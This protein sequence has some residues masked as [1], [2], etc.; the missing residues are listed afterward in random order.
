[1]TN[2]RFSMEYKFNSRSIAQVFLDLIREFNGKKVE[3]KGFLSDEKDL[4]VK[5]L[6]NLCDDSKS[7]FSFEDRVIKLNDP[8]YIIGDIC[9]RLQDLFTIESRLWHSFPIV[10]A[11]YLFLGNF[12]EFGGNGIEC[13]IY[14][15]ALKLIAPKKIFLIKGCHEVGDVG[16]VRDV[17]DFQIKN[18]FQKECTQKYGQKIGLK[19]WQLI[20]GVFD[21]LPIAAI[22]NES[23]FC[24][25]GGIPQSIEKVRDINDMSTDRKNSKQ[26]S[27]VVNEV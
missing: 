4:F 25:N 5:Y 24:A 2:Q 17:T 22:I 19:V 27:V 15:F 9:G 18:N 21:V 11:N 1:M 6:T 14:L 23:I 10:S 26:Y 12:V 7:L 8:I 3:D 20:N 16:D 13:I